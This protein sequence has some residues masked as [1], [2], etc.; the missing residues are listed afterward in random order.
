M[1]KLLLAP[2]LLLALNSAKAQLA[3]ENFSST[4]PAGWVLINNDGKTSNFTTDAAIKAALT[5]NAWIPIELT[6]GSGD[7][8]M[9][10]SSKFTP[11][12]TADRWLVTPSFTV[13]SANTIFKW[14]DWNLG[15]AEK[16]QVYIS[17]TA[18]TT[19]ASFT[20]KLYDAFASNNALTN[21]AISLTP[22]NG[23]TVRLAFRENNTDVWAYVIDKVQSSILANKNEMALS[24]VYPS[25]NAVGRYTLVGSTI[26]VQGYITN[27]GAADIT[28]F[29]AK[30]QVGSGPVV[31]EVKTA[32]V[33][34][35]GTTSFTFST[36][37]T[38]S[39]A[40]A[41]PTIKVW[42][43]LP[44]DPIQTNDTLTTTFFGVPKMPT[45]KPLIEEGTGTWCG[46]CVRGTVYMDSMEKVN[47]H[48]VSLVAVHNSPSDPMQNPAY[49]AFMGTKI[50]GYPSAL[51]D[52]AAVG[53]PSNAFQYYNG[54]TSTVGFSIK[55]QKSNFGFAD[56]G[57]KTTLSGTTVTAR[58]FVKPVLSMNGGFSVALVLTE[59]GV[60][61]TALQTNYYSNANPSGSVGTLASSL[62]NFNTLPYKVAS[63]PLIYNAVARGI[64]P[65]ATGGSGSLPASITAGVT[66]TYDFAPITLDP[67]WKTANMRAILLFINNADGTVLNTENV[68]LGSSAGATSIKENYVGVND[69]EVYPNP[70][71][72]MATT[73]FSLIEKSN[74]SIEIIDMSGKVIKTIEN[75]SFN[76]GTYEIPTSVSE[77][78]SGLYMIKIATDF[79]TTT[80]RLSVVK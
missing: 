29:T 44:G 5:A 16:V 75:K 57:L 46:Y 4:L 61:T 40:G 13:T 59:N 48:N 36:P 55:G 51:Y 14:Q 34:P 18:G 22:Y 62:Y 21:H 24:G 30:Y 45:K 1:K 33:M 64:Y 9:L 54:Y 52:R 80:E 2:A 12:G 58:G 19:A 77:L 35:L 72:E 50:S 3:L 15:S 63:P 79:G 7:F 78:A 39:A 23:Q 67:S 25:A 68:K 27:N 56:M 8:S 71:K 28:S 70:A 76:A 69:V 43:E 26:P 66:Y 31:S 53:D 49:D 37:V 47:A 20:T 38:V 17:P 10:S 74:V 32:T 6:A 11:A 41:T 42:V 65:T 73:K 60:T